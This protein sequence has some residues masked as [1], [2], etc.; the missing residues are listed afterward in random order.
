MSRKHKKQQVVSSHPLTHITTPV[1]QQ[2]LEMRERLMRSLRRQPGVLHPLDNSLWSFYDRETEDLRRARPLAQSRQYKR[3]DGSPAP[4][5]RKPVQDRRGL[6]W[7]RESMRLSF[8][9]PRKTL[10]CRRRQAR[11]RVLFAL[12]KVGGK[13]GAKRNRSIKA[14]WSAQSYIRCK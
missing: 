13:G 4:F 6:L 9:D 5:G 2:D 3:V 10:V 12:Q 7:M 11:K 1:T 14:R 8:Y